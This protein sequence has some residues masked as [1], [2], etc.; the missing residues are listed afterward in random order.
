M[1]DNAYKINPD[2]AIAAYAPNQRFCF[3]ADFT[4]TSSPS[5]NVNELGPVVIRKNG[6]AGGLLPGDIRAG[7]YVDVVYDGTYFQMMSPVG[8]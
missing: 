1:P 2:P 7:Q 4:N 6:G 8:Q 5:L 3:I